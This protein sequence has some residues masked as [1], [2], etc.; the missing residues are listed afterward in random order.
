MEF[1][2]SNL[3]NKKEITEKLSYEAGVLLA[4]L[5]LNQVNHYGDLT[6]E[7]SLNPDPHIPFKHKFE[8]SFLECRHN[9]PKALLEKSWQYYSQQTINQ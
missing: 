8:E 1:F 4:S 6:Q 7:H 3:L 2:S 9:L 5:H